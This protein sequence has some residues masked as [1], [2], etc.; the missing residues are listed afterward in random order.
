MDL[1]HYGTQRCRLSV[2]AGVLGGTHCESVWMARYTPGMSPGMSKLQQSANP[3]SLEYLDL[4]TSDISGSTDG[5]AT[6]MDSFINARS[7]PVNPLVLI[8]EE[9]CHSYTQHGTNC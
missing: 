7:T 2:A 1:F 9:V 8:W 4:T 5:G 3:S 6:A